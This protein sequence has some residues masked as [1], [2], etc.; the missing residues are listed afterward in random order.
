[1]NW[2]ITIPV[3]SMAYPTH[4]GHSPKVFPVE[5]RLKLFG[6]QKYAAEGAQHHGEDD[7]PCLGYDC[8]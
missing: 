5:C 6:E 1:M 4:D 7:A 2:A 8:W 3:T